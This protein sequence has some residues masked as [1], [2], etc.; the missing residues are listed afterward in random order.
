MFHLN[1]TEPNVTQLMGTH[2]YM[3]P[4]YVH[5]GNLSVK[6]DVY[7]FG[8]LI[9]EII[10]GKRV[11]AVFN[12]YGGDHHLLTHAWHVWLSG[13]YGE[14]ADPYLRGQFEEAELMKRIQIALLCVEKNPDHRPFMQE[15]TMML[16]KDG[17]VT[18]D[19]QQPAY[20][21]IQLGANRPVN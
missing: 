16:S 14:L 10:S 6:Y 18:H 2:G 5:D 12:Q 15:I 21:D 13:N 20:L 1:G 8:V 4:E 3:P 11:T 19:P 17:A 9:L 7:S